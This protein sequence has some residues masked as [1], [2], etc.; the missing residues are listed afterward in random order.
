MRRAIPL[1]LLVLGGPGCEEAIAPNA[2][3]T[4]GADASPITFERMAKLPA[5]GWNVPRGVSHSPDGKL[6]TF[7]ASE[8]GSDVLTLFAFDV[9]TR[10][11]TPLVRGTDLVPQ[12]A[13]RSKSA[14]VSS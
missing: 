3:R 14:S 4:P 12:D 2:P 1:V 10:A 5:P 9:A 6:V 11:T 8:N 13:P 7:L